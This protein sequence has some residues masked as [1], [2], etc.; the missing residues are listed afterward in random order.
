[1]GTDAPVILELVIVV[2]RILVEIIR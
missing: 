1:M 2:L